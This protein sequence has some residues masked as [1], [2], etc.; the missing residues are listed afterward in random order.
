MAE[1]KGGDSD[2]ILSAP[3]PHQG[4]AMKPFPVQVKGITHFHIISHK[5]MAHVSLMLNRNPKP[6]GV[7]IFISEFLIAFIAGAK[8]V[9]VNK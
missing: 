3:E 4:M 5:F 8:E 9:I 2:I 1:V 6:A 7:D